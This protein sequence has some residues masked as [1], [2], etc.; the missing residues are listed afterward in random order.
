MAIW[1]LTQERVEKLLKQIGEKQEEIDTLIKLSPKDIWAVDLEAFMDEWNLQI[2]EEGKRKKKIAGITR[3]AS[4]KLGIGAGKGA[5]G[6][7]KRKAGDSDSDDSGSDFG[8][9][10][11]KAKPKKEGLLTYLQQEPAKKPTA[12]EAL[13]NSSAFGSTVPQKQGTLLAH[14]VKKKEESPAQ[15]DGASDSRPATADSTAP[16]K[17]GRPAV[18]KAVKKETRVIDSDDDDDTDVFAAVAKEPAVKEPTKTTV[19]S[20]GGR[21]ATKQAPKYNLGSDSDDDDDDLLGDVSSMVKTIGSATNG[22]PMFKATASARPG[23]NGSARPG[24]AKKNSPIEIDDDE[25]NY[26]GLMPQPSPK[27]PAPRNVNDTIMSSDDDDS[28]LGVKKPAAK[29]TVKPKAA[30]K[31]APKP[32]VVAKKP[33]AQSPAAKAYAKKHGKEAAAAPASKKKAITIDSDEDEDMEDAD[34]IA[35]DILSDEDED[36]DEP[37]PKPQPAAARLGRRAAAAKPAKYV[38]S[39]DDEEEAEASEPSFEDE[40]SE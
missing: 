25:T 16:P 11:K 36:E 22:V 4:Q 38:V 37:T 9:V 26:E 33:A 30:A 20:R 18:A 27:R 32:K 19:A 7:K 15:V 14:L 21:A 8:P 3:R 39:D 31:P 1:S 40:D 13:K 12:A 28:D 29:P 10:K 23:S 34:A 17:R 5:K 2:E 6:K 24:A 35:N